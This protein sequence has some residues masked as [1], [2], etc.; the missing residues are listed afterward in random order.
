[1]FCLVPMVCHFTADYQ[2][3]MHT[4]L[5]PAS[6]KNTLVVLSAY[7]EGKTGTTYISKGGTTNRSGD[8]SGISAVYQCYQCAMI[9]HKG[10]YK[11]NMFW[12]IFFGKVDK[13]K[14]A[15]HLI[16]RLQTQVENIG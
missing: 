2:P 4:T 1:M 8:G 15:E 5:L 7:L 14:E 9:H 13:A 10:N 11:S 16:G 12:Y 3:G 6:T